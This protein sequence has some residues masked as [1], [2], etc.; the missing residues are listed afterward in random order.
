[1]LKFSPK[2]SNNKIWR[3]K[4]DLNFQH[5]FFSEWE[6][7][8]KWVI[9]QKHVLELPTTE[10]DSNWF[11]IQMQAHDIAHEA[12]PPGKC[13]ILCTWVSN[14]ARHL[15]SLLQWDKKS[16]ISSTF[17]R[18]N[19]KTSSSAE[20]GDVAS[21]HWWRGHRLQPI[22]AVYWVGQMGAGGLWWQQ[23][24]HS[25]QSSTESSVTGGWNPICRVTGT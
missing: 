10:E 24:R 20:I 17:S 5:F 3:K 9:P 11:H 21:P 18:Y 4:E 6:F 22:S 16:Q 14:W 19:H 2:N 8:N 23:Q 25:S 15:H 7:Q 1:M 12:W 13:I